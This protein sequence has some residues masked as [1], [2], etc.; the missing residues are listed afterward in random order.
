M[1]LIIFLGAIIS[2]HE[3]IKLPLKEHE[4]QRDLGSLSL[5]LEYDT[6]N[7]SQYEFA[8]FVN[9]SLAKFLR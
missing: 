9:S 7:L 2:L 4:P 1:Y 8:V 3:N 6:P 5:I